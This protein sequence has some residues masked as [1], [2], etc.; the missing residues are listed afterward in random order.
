MI[1]DGPPVNGEN[2]GGPRRAPAASGAIVAISCLLVGFTLA[3][4]GDAFGRADQQKPAE[5][6]LDKAQTQETQAL[7]KLVTDV[8]LGAPAPSDFP[9]AWQNHFIKAR[10]RR[11]FVPYVVSIPQ[12]SLANPSVAMYLRV[13]RKG[14]EPVPAPRVWVSLEEKVYYKTGDEKFGTGQGTYMP[15][16]DAIK[17]GYQAA[18][19]GPGSKD[20]KAALRPESAFE[21]VYFT[22]LKTPE[23]KDPLRLIRALSVLPGDYT[24][25]LVVRER[26]AGDKKSSAE[27]KTSLIKE[28]ITVPDFWQ[29][30][31]A[32]S[33]IIVAE[34][35]ELLS[36]AVPESQLAENPYDFGKTRL[37]PAPERFEEGRSFDHLSHLQYSRDRQKPCDRECF[38]QGR[39]GEKFF[40]KTNPQ[41]FNAETLPPAFDTAAGHQLVAGQSVPLGSF[42]EGEYR[43]EIKVTDKIAGKSIVQN[44]S[45]AVTP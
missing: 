38:S 3:V 13:V 14:A 41:I 22:D 26:P 21:D 37:I 10:D 17:A 18:P 12:G 39:G 20:A 19:P 24:V 11:T 7:V 30:G 5:R 45:F 31:L 43:L 16:A 40:N 42:P 44:V 2:V 1:A 15:E 28:S 23:G 34:K 27:A 32:T 4:D 29:P 8:T 36:A 6:K 35:V 33:S 25:Y 9:M